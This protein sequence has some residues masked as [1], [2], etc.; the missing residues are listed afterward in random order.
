MSAVRLKTWSGMSPLAQKSEVWHS[1]LYPVGVVFQSKSNL[2]QRP[3]QLL[4][5]GLDLQEP[6]ITETCSA[7]ALNNEQVLAMLW[8]A[9]AA[10]KGAVR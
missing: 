9:M 4:S 8:Q 2:V 6:V 1:P 3:L 5:S 10:S 7:T